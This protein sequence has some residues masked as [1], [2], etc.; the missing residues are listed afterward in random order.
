MRPN[1]TGL[2][3]LQAHEGVLHARGKILAAL[4]APLLTPFE[5]N[6]LFDL[7]DE[8][9]S[10]TVGFEEFKNKCPSLAAA[11]CLTCV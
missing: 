9:G 3:A 7:C 2:P 8:N 10:G 1:S 6:T 4:K 5:I 11:G